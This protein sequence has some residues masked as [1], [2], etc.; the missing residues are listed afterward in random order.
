MSVRFSLLQAI[1][2]F[3]I[4]VPTLGRL[5]IFVLAATNELLVAA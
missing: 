4:A 3:L 5:G 2:F 1:Y